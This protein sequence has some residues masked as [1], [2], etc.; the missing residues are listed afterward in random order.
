MEIFLLWLILILLIYLVFVE[1]HTSVRIGSL[2]KNYQRTALVDSCVIIDGRIEQLLATGWM[3]DNLI[4]PD[5]IIYELQMLADSKDATKRNR[6]RAALDLANHLAKNYPNVTTG[7]FYKQPKIMKIDEKLVNVAIDKGFSLITNDANLTKVARLKGI[8]V[9]NFNELSMEV[10]INI[11]PDEVIEI[12]L[13]DKGE[14]RN[15]A[16]GYLDDGTMVV[17]ANA[18]SMLNKMVKVRIE[19]AHQSSHGRMYFA[20]L[21]KSETKARR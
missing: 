16:V 8:E 18:K 17:V 4:I 10:R 20:S 21:I 15:Q 9:L 11:L 3:A 14:G 12:K 5:F 1:K 2:S 6:A 13:T 7:K 19:K